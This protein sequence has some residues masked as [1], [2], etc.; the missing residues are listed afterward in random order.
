MDSAEESLHIARRWLS[1]FERRSVDELVS[2]YQPDARHS[3]PKL[4]LQRPETGGFL[5][6]RA[7]LREWWAG[8]FARL[9]GLRYLERSLTADG[10]RVFMEYLRQNP[11]DPD[12][13]VAEVLEL[14]GGLIAE[15]RVYHG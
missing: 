6:G 14:R 2:L 7:A 10:Q 4:R 5:I 11:G 9:P 1:C 15:S 12:L 3:S 13:P 8:A